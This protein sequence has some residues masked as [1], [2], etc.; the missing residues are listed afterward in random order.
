[1][2]FAGFFGDLEMYVLHV[3]YVIAHGL[4][5]CP[6][7]MLSLIG[8]SVACNLVSY[9]YSSFIQ[10]QW[11]LMGSKLAN[12]TNVTSVYSQ[13]Y[14]VRNYNRKCSKALLNSLSAIRVYGCSFACLSSL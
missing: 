1:M 13:T 12:L 8:E 14:S 6:A 7:N 5:S 10:M 2:A 11:W 9:S 4:Q 3:V